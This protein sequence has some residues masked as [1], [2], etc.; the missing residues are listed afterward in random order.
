MKATVLGVAIAIF[1]FL[2][3]IVLLQN[4]IAPPPPPP[5]Q[6]TFGAVRAEATRV[7]EHAT[8]TAAERNVMATT[9]ALQTATIRIQT[10]SAGDAAGASAMAT[11][12]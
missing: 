9:E 1:I 11:P 8:H 2:L 7:A 10:R 5:L 3:L 4:Q 6:A 12:A